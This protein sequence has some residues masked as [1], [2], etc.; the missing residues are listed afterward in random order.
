MNDASVARSEF[1]GRDVFVL[2]QTGR[3][4]KTT[5]DIFTG[6]GHFVVGAIHDDDDTF[7]FFDPWY[8]IVEMAGSD[9]PNYVVSGITG[10]ATGTLSGWLVIT[11][12]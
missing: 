3:Y 7:V 6:C 8:T 1:D 11:H 5:V 2:G 10:S 12:H 9:L 4:D